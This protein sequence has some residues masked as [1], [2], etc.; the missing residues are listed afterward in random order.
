MTV[1]R[2][3]VPEPDTSQGR[4]RALRDRGPAR[5]SEP[6][7]GRG[8]QRHSP[9]RRP[10]LGN[11]RGPPA[12]EKAQKALLMDRASKCLQVTLKMVHPGVPAV[13]WWVK[14]PALLQLWRRSQLWLGF[15]P[16]PGNFPTPWA[17]G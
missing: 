12:D 15:D 11:V 9:P 5:G 6:A 8:G 17:W 7:R 3:R 10:R 4:G 1:T 13:V 2:R 16:G 14:D